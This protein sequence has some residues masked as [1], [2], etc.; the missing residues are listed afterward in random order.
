MQ[1]ALW[2]CRWPDLLLAEVEIARVLVDSWEL[3]NGLRVEREGLVGANDLELQCLVVVTGLRG[4]ELH[5]ELRAFL[6][7][8]DPSS[9][10]IS[11]GW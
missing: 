8:E 9:L 10:P 7:F 1:E 2:L 6:R 11:H 5:V 4:E 3:A